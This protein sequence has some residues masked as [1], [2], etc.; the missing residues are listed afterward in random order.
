M[1]E[2]RRFLGI[3]VKALRE[4]GLEGERAEEVEKL[5]VRSRRA[6]SSLRSDV[7]SSIQIV[8]LDWLICFWLVT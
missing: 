3:A 2:A 1:L 8:S 4:G 6:L 7:I 5:E